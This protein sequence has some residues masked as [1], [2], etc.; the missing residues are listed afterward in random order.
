MTTEEARKQLKNLFGK[1]TKDSNS[2]FYSVEK[3]SRNLLKNKRKSVYEK[4]RV[5]YKFY[6]ETEN[7]DTILD[8]EDEKTPFRTPFIEQKKHIDRLSI[9]YSIKAPF[10]SFHADIANIKF[11]SKSAVDPHHCLLCV[12]HLS[13]KIYTYP[14][15]KRSLLANKME[16]FYEEIETKRDGSEQMRI[17]TDLEFRQRE[18]QKL[19]QKY[20]LMFHIKIRGGKA[21]AAKQKIREFKKILQ[22]S[23][24]MHKQ[25]S[26]KRIEPKKLI[27]CAANNLNNIPSQKYGVSPN[28]VEENIQQDEKLRRIFDF[29]RLV[30]VQKYT[31]RYKCNDI[32]KDDKKRETLRKPL[33]IGE[34]VFALA[35]R[36]KK[37]H[38]PGVFIRVQLRTNHFLTEMRH[39]L[40]EELLLFTIFISGF[41]KQLAVK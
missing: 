18:T 9:F 27:Q 10:E 39:I 35:E 17:Q 30:K 11:L 1:L 26:T 14:L 38:A 2:L 24:R 36:L 33:L 31:E 4:A 34:K 12:N 25:S 8:E 21:F 28:F 19:N 7:Q 23:K 41:Q 5:F 3:I 32:R 20:V 16:Q 29:Y 22:K 37:K 6:N 13:L 15:K 40:L